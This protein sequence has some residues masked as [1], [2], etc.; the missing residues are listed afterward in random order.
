VCQI[1]GSPCILRDEKRGVKLTCDL[2]HQRLDSL[3][4]QLNMAFASDKCSPQRI[5]QLQ[6]DVALL[7]EKIASEH[8]PVEPEEVYSP[9]T[10]MREI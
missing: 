9:H 5:V 10:E 6:V 8:V 3:L 1:S 7:R 2:D 4:A